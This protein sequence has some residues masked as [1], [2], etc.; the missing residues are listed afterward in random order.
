MKNLYTIKTGYTEKFEI[1]SDNVE[2]ALSEWGYLP[3]GATVN[4]FLEWMHQIGC[5]GY[6]IEDD[7]KKDDVKI[8]RTPIA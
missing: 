8:I 4:G 1:Y 2:N 6:I 3:F 5:W 7:V